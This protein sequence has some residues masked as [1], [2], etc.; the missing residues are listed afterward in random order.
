MSVSI[1]K[2]S[3]LIVVDVQNDFCS[4][5]A[6]AVPEGDKVVYVLN[7]YI[8]RFFAKEAAIFATRDWHPM[9]HVSFKEH[10]GLWMPHCVQRTKGADFHKDLKLPF[11]VEIISKGFLTEKDAY[12]GFEGTELERRLK[13]RGITR[14]FV[15]GLAA[16]YC[17]KHTVLDALVRGFETY[18]LLDAIQGVSV[19]PTDSSEA[20]SEMQR[21]GAKAITLLDV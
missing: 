5:G 2:F 14:V 11:G 21:A 19:K 10:C 3:A 13:H 6:L 20:V 18:L 1:D 16:D 15:G 4:G 7:D 8:A 17:V 12:T 9:H